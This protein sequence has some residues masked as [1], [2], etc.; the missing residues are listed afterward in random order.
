[1]LAG[2]SDCEFQL[3]KKVTIIKLARSG[4]DILNDHE[5]GKVHKDR[6]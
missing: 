1:M 3:R 6:A 5:S 2:K 4:Q